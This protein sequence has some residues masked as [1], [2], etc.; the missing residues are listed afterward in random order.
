M[1]TRPL[2]QGTLTASRAIEPKPGD[3]AAAGEKKKRRDYADVSLAGELVPFVMEDTGR[4]GKEGMDFVKMIRSELQSQGNSEDQFDR[5][6]GKVWW[7]DL[8]DSLGMALVRGK[9]MLLHRYRWQCVGLGHSG[10]EG[11][12]YLTEQVD[13]ALRVL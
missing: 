2:R 1:I 6:N 12:Q 11:E 10:W 9:I 5:R 4:V 8:F 13:S 3:E 7:K